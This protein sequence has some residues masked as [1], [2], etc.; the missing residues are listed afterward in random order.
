MRP[1]DDIRN[2]GRI[3]AE[4]IFNS[5]GRTVRDI[6]A[7]I[8]EIFRSEVRLAKAELKEQAAGAAKAAAFYAA[9]GICGLFVVALILLACVYAL[10]LWVQPWLA[11]LIVAFAVAAIGGGAFIMARD[12]SRQVTVVPRETVE[13]IKENVRWAQKRF[14]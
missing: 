12:Q 11:A 14:K 7:N 10:S 6:I 1:E 4:A 13:S 5:F 3:S 2:D 8:Q 9:A